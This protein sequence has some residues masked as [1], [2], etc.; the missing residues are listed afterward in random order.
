MQ[1][2]S[3]TELLDQKVATIECDLIRYENIYNDPN[4]PA[5]IK[6]ATAGVL[7]HLRCE[8]SRIGKVDFYA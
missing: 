7:H 3:V 8:L 6:S 5:V 1:E 2:I 4:T